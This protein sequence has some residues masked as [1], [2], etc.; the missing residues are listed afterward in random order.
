MRKRQKPTPTHWI[1]TLYWWN[2]F[3]YLNFVIAFFYCIWDG[4]LKE[5]VGDIVY[6]IKNHKWT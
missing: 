1:W 4:G 6:S 2:P 3:V 5:W